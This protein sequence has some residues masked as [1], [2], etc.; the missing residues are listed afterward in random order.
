MVIYDATMKYRKESM[1]TMKKKGQV[2]YHD[3]NKFI[4]RLHIYETL[5]LLKR[6]IKYVVSYRSMMVDYQI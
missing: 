2:E 4:Y 5:L 3:V 6:R 1:K